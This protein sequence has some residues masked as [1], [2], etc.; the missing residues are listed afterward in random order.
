MVAKKQ[1]EVVDMSTRGLR[2]FTTKPAGYLVESRNQKQ[3]L[4][5][6]RSDPDAPRSFDAGDKL[7]TTRPGKYRTIA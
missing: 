2:W 5:E 6:W 3:R 7:V 1:D 4:D